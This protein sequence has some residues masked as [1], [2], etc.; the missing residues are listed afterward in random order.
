MVNTNTL[1]QPIRASPAVRNAMAPSVSLCAMMAMTPKNQTKMV[2][3][4]EAMIMWRCQNF[5]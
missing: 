2:T 1:N 4:P 5:H 3:P